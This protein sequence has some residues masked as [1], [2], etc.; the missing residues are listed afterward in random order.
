MDRILFEPKSP[1]RGIEFYHVKLKPE[2]PSIVKGVAFALLYYDTEIRCL[3]FDRPP[4]SQWV[5]SLWIKDGS[6]EIDLAAVLKHSGLDFIEGYCSHGDF[7]PEVER[8][9]RAIRESDAFSRL[10]EDLTSELFQRAVGEL[11]PAGP[12][13]PKTITD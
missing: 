7:C 1:G 8:L 4:G 3:Y 5:V 6:C 12:L 9:K 2:Y 11:A 13:S 10:R